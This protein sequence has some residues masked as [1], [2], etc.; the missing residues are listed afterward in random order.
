MK[1]DGGAA[2]AE[3]RP[4]ATWGPSDVHI[5]GLGVYT[6]NLCPFYCDRGREA[7]M[8]AQDHSA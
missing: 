4:N 2:G 5:G 3:G 7:V 6:A 8:T 1:L